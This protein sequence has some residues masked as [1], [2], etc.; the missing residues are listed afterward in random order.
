MTRH[1]RENHARLR[2]AGRALP[3]ARSSL[4]F[5]GQTLDSKIDSLR[6]AA[7][8]RLRERS[9]TLARL[10]GRLDRRSPYGRL[11]LWA[12]RTH[13]LGAKLSF[14]REVRIGR[15]RQALERANQALHGNTR[16]VAER[17]GQRLAMMA[18]RWEVRMAERRQ[19]PVTLKRNVA[20]VDADLRRAIWE[21][22]RRNRI[23]SANIAQV[24]AAVNYRSV[25]ARGYALVL[26]RS[27]AAL[28]CADDA[29]ATKSF[30]IRFVDGDVAAVTE[31]AARPK[32]RA[33]PP[34]TTSQET[35]F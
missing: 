31:S 33:R 30:T 7:S 12:E 26:D 23:S 29:K 18:R 1:A 27:G 10:V 5:A 8:G 15:G 19:S 21:T 24:F 28:T 3:S 34:A 25:L 6:A 17:N 13:T 16:R 4:S 14:H 20:R 22:M 9:L 32:R 11:T 2:G 35:L